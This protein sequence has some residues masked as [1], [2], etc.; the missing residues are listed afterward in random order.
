MLFANKTKEEMAMRF[1]KRFPEQEQNR[2]LATYFKFTFVREP[3]ERLVSAY[4]DKF[5]YLRSEDI[6]YR[7]LHGRDILK[8]YRP[9]AS[10]RSLEEI[11]DIR[12]GEFMEYLVK[13]GSDKTTRVMDQHWDNY[14][15][16]CGMCDIEYDFIGH[17]ETMEQDLSEFIKAARLSPQNAKR[18]SG[19]KHTPSKTS[20]SLL[21]YYSQIPLKWIDRLGQIYN[22]SF[23]MFGYNFPGPLKS[24]YEN[25]AQSAIT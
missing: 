10:R 16:V 9:N 14:V 13:K 23:I 15:N 19:Y 5:V 6:Y 11:N 12:F 4:K 1:F 18:F 8:N 22:A 25:I 24:L 2:M 7:R 20:A 17:Y 3:L 21:N